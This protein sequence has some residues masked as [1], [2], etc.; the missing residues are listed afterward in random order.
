MTAAP[1]QQQ[2]DT[3]EVRL[4]ARRAQLR[5]AVPALAENARNVVAKPSTLLLAAGVGVLLERG[6]A[7]VL[8][9]VRTAWATTDLIRLVTKFVT[10]FDAPVHS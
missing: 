8:P 7:T 10:A 1:L 3:T 4:A 6:G 9:S 5:K 2:I